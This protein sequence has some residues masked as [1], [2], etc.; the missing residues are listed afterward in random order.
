MEWRNVVGYEGLYEVSCEGDIRSLDKIV[1]FNTTLYASG[2]MTRLH[3]GCAMSPFL[4]NKGYKR[5]G[6]R[7]CGKR[8]KYFVH[9]LVAEAFVSNTN[10]LETVNHI[11]EDKTNNN[12][13][14]LEWMTRGD[15]VRYYHERREVCI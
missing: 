15:N 11:D 9:R 4:T 12:A 13:S 3:R 6:L 5:V 14:N 2:T 1:T 8:S 7:R 10:E